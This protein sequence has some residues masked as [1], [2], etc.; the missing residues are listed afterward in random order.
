[1]ILLLSS[2]GIYI[3]LQNFISVTFGDGIQTIRSD[4]IKE[5]M[6]CL[7]ARITKVQ[8]I[9]IV[10]S[11]VLSGCLFGW[12]RASKIGKF[13]RALSCNS[14]L[15]TISGINTDKVIFQTY[16]LAAAIMSLAGALFAFDLDMYPTMGMNGLLLGVV[17]VIVG[18]VGSIPGVSLGALLLGFAQHFGIWNIGSQWQDAIAFIILFIFLLI[19]PHGVHGKRDIKVQI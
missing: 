14:T 2:I 7:G 13:I 4:I 9:T 18:G 3:I 6:M 15:A 11:F 5:G 8:L 12:L 1:M 10:T 17:A 16:G 19:R